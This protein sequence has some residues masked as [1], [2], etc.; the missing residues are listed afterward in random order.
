MKTASILTVATL[1]FLTVPLLADGKGDTDWAEKAARGYEEKAEWARK[2]GKPRAAEIYQRMAEIKREAGRA[3][4]QGREFSWQEYHELEGKLQGLREEHAKKEGGDHEERPGEGFLKAAEE[5]RRKA[6]RARESGD[7]DKA[8]IYGKLAA[9]K[10][11]AA[12]AAKEGKGYD[13]TEYH[14]LRKQ[15]DGEHEKHGP[16]KEWNKDHKEQHDSKPAPAKLNIE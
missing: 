11:A 6:A 7:T 15:L 14:Q 13:W 4:R 5:Y 12:M 8:E 9:M 10:V 2:Q 3:S 16:D 1:A